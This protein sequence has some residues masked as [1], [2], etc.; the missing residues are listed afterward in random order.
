VC[1]SFEGLAVEPN[2][3]IRHI[4]KEPF[5]F[6]ELLKKLRNHKPVAS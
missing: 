4:H 1:E 2:G 5:F 6:D 3:L